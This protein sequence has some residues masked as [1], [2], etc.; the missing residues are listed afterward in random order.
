MNSAK[1]RRGTSSTLTTLS[2]VFAFAIVTSMTVQAQYGGSDR[3]GYGNDTY[4]VAENQGYRDGIDHGAE[5]A[6]DGERYNPEGTRHYKSATEGYRSEYGNKEAYKRS[7]REGFRRGYEVGY[8]QSAGNR[9]N[10]GRDPYDDD[11]YY[12]AD[13]GRYG[14]SGSDDPSYRGDDGRYGRTGDYGGYGGYGRN[15]A[16]RI[17][18][19]QGYRDGVDH[20]AEHAREGKRFNP[21]ST[22]HYKDAT[23]GY[24]SE[25]GNK[26]QYKQT[27]RDAFRRGYDEGYRRDSRGSYGRRNSRSRVADILGGILSRP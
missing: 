5:H 24:R 12:R 2:M 6:R 8:R 10:G 27:Y 18:Q 7:Y 14:R 16:Y 4:R 11:P 20:G 13:D 1:L 25:Y 22:R 3:Y 15:D 26:E 17:A 21:E 23:E 19:E 9:R